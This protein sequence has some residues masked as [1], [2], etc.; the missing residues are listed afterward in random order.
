M[1]ISA[2]INTSLFC[3]AA[4]STSMAYST[5]L[6]FTIDSP[7][8]KLLD[9]KT[10]VVDITRNISEYAENISPNKW[11]YLDTP[12]TV[13]VSGKPRYTRTKMANIQDKTRNAMLTV[14]TMSGGFGGY[15]IRIRDNEPHSDAVTMS[16]YFDGEQLYNFTST[17]FMNTEYLISL[18]SNIS[19]LDPNMSSPKTRST[20]KE[21]NEAFEEISF[22]MKSKRTMTVVFDKKRYNFSLKGSDNAISSVVF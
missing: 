9:G 8:E 15:S 16:I 7:Y 6:T 13:V 1:K 4:L 11:T 22:L 2:I 20:I 21:Y 19:L 18:Y 12:N 5:P 17:K 10:A 14:Q 3:F